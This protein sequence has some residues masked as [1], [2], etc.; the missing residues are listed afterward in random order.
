MILMQ[1]YISYAACGITN[2]SLNR[3]HLPVTEAEGASFL[4]DNFFSGCLVN[5]A[6]EDVVQNTSDQFK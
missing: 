5:L 1:E 2:S 6:A 4:E 3:V